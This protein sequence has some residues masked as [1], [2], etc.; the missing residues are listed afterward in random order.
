MFLVMSR[1]MTVVHPMTTKFKRSS[2]VF[3]CIA[4]LVGF[5]CSISLSVGLTAALTM[6]EIPNSVC[7]PFADPRKSATVII[8]IVVFICVTQSC[9]GFLIALLHVMF[10]YKLTKSQQS[11]SKTGTNKNTALVTQ[12]SLLTLCPILCWCTTNAEN[13]T[14]LFMS[15][16]PV[17]LIEWNIVMVIPLCPLLTSSILTCKHLVKHWQSKLWNP[18]WNSLVGWYIFIVAQ[19]TMCSSANCV[20]GKFIM[21]RP[22]LC[23]GQR[24]T[25]TKHVAFVSKF[26]ISSSEMICRI[27]V[28][29]WLVVWLQGKSTE[30][31]NLSSWSG[32]LCHWGGRTL[33]PNLFSDICMFDQKNNRPMSS[34]KFQVPSLENRT[35]NRSCACNTSFRSQLKI[36]SWRLVEL[37]GVKLCLKWLP[38]WEPV[39]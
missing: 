37:L 38:F 33:S 21:Q 1:F 31:T 3:K 27:K 25:N 28:K 9:S 6:L 20:C 7:S 13:I 10:L 8:V 16:F 12:V 35:R 26:S 29:A 5:G 14:I 30:I 18:C 19:Q 15:K 4:C 2:F 32:F 39:L 17:E 24:S 11:V 36:N 23:S 22:W 34:G